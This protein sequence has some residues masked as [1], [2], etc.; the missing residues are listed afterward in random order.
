MEEQE[1]FSSVQC[2]V[3]SYS[4][5]GSVM[6]PEVTVDDALVDVEVQE[7]ELSE[8]VL[9]TEFGEEDNGQ[10]VLSINEPEVEEKYTVVTREAD[11]DRYTIAT[12]ELSIDEHYASVSSTEPRPMEEESNENETSQQSWETEKCIPTS[13]D[14]NEEDNVV[15]QHI[16][17]VSEDNVSSLDIDGCIDDNADIHLS[18]DNHGN[19]EVSEV[20]QERLIVA[21]DAESVPGNQ[22][23]I[24]KINRQEERSEEGAVQPDSSTEGYDVNTGPMV[25][26]LCSI[27][28]KEFMSREQHDRHMELDHPGMSVQTCTET[29]TFEA[30][31]VTVC[32]ICHAEFPTSKRLGIHMRDAH[33]V[34]SYA[35]EVCKKVFATLSHVTRHMMS[36]S[37]KKAFQCQEC[38]KSFSQEIILARHLR[39]H[40]GE[41]PYECDICGKTFAQVSNRNVHR[42]THQPDRE[43]L[44]KF[45]CRLCSKTFAQSGNLNVHMR[46]HTGEKPYQCSVCRK[47]L[48]TSSNLKAHM[49]THDLCKGLV[50]PQTEEYDYNFKTELPSMTLPQPELPP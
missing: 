19:L 21:E 45:G 34:T 37:G 42:K 17:V 31:G 4:D 40:T 29:E 13:S 49:K 46:S 30:G 3:V 15:V 2:A 48:S 23:F 11:E 26:I 33:E 16:Y 36:H 8:S 27:C 28:E 5:D 10:Y 6:L 25:I 32:G 44:K 7:V 43:I 38:D 12:N 24:V 41:K 35:C 22:K 50:L 47:C 18:Y 14:G 1:H 20:Q 9:E 39:T